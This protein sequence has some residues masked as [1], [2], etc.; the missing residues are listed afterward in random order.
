MTSVQEN[1]A[2]MSVSS[3]AADNGPSWDMAREAAEIAGVELLGTVT[4]AATGTVTVNG[5]LVDLE[6]RGLVSYTFDTTPY[7]VS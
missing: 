4:R 3:L 1:H 7:P 5:E 2:V 6:E